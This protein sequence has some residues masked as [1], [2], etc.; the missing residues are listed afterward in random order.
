MHPSL[1]SLLEPDAPRFEILRAGLSSALP[2]L[3]RLAETPQD[4]EWHAEGDVATH[5]AWV[6]AEAHALATDLDGDA[7]LTLLL[8]ALLHDIAKPLTT[9]TREIEGRPRVVAPRHSSIGRDWLAYRLLDLGLPFAVLLSVLQLV[10]EHHEPKKLVLKDRGER[11]YLALSRRVDVSLLHKL[12]LADMRGRDC[13]DKAKQLEIVEFFRMFC[14]EY[15]LMS[16]DSPWRRWRHTLAS[17][18]V[19][20]PI[21][22]LEYTL[23][24]AARDH[25]AGRIHAPEEALSRTF[26]ARRA[27]LPS[28]TLLCGPSGSG[29]STWVNGDRSIEGSIT[30]DVISLDALRASLTGKASSQQRNGQ[31]R[32]AAREALREALRRRRDV[33]WDA[34][35]VRRDVREAV[36]SL[37]RD[38]GARTTLMVFHAPI[39]TL[40]ARN[41]ARTGR[42]VPVNI[43]NRQI[44]RF[45]WPTEDEADRTIYLD[46]HH[47]VSRDTRAVL[48]GQTE[49]AR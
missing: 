49:H 44:D 9:K 18:L 29:K 24:R 47:E 37:A 46:K 21:A 27:G 25:A 8:G 4:E 22:H 33:I 42:S 41:R 28:L 12:A 20:E 3:D 23:S 1:T 32:Q 2:L 40:H 26:E 38:Y 45:Q 5:T 6:L 14:R 17:A 16:G 13:V 11:D 31:V 39:A 30:A 35:N 10:A 43:L 48:L 7:R 19:G 15:Q 36:F 34:T